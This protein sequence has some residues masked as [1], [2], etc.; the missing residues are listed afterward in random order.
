MRATTFCAKPKHTLSAHF[1]F[2]SFRS[3]E[4][5]RQSDLKHKQAVADELHVDTQGNLNEA[6]RKYVCTGTVATYLEHDLLPGSELGPVHL[7]HARGR[8]RLGVD[9][10]ELFADPRS[11][12]EL[13]VCCRFTQKSSSAKHAPKN[14]MGG[15]QGGWEGDPLR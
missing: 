8:E 13:G 5:V 3:I 1:R 11:S 14:G 10:R 7:R 15:R 12:P 6:P 2:Y 9:V 4:N